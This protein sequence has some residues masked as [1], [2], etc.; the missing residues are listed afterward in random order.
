MATIISKSM[1]GYIFIHGKHSGCEYN[2]GSL[3]NIANSFKNN[4]LVS[5]ETYPW[6]VS[7]SD[8]KFYPR[9][10]EDCVN[11]IDQSI[12]RLTDQGADRIFLVGHSIGGNACL[13]YASLKT[14]FAGIVLLAPAHNI[15]LGFYAQIHRWSTIESKKMIDQ[16]RGDQ[17]GHFVDMSA[18][19]DIVVTETQAKTYYS[20]MNI[21]GSA[22]MQLNVSKISKPIN[23][24]C[25][26]GT[27][28]PTQKE[29]GRTVYN[30]IPKTDK[31]K[32]VI[33]KGD[34]SSI[35][36]KEEIIFNWINTL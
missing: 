25:V 29:F 31:S 30:L 32:M 10:F 11:Q 6:G 26:S 35:C 5:F 34:H 20:I 19:G 17:I 16:G 24:L 15:H 33:V 21:N 36:N 13:Y 8:N 1:D 12:S 9:I 14:N 3:Y 22:N 28:D 23:V 2:D 7:E 27:D 18:D 4:H